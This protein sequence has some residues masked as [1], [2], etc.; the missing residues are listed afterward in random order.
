M[1]G[2]WPRWRWCEREQRG[3]STVSTGISDETGSSMFVHPL[4]PAERQA[5]EDGVRLAGDNA[6]RR[7]QILLASDRGE[8]VH[9]IATSLGCDEQTVRE[10]IATFNTA[11]LGAVMPD[12]PL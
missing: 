9:L 6:L 12:V 8:P 2:W 7:Y 3:E 10:A 4:A 1:H 5:L 11:G